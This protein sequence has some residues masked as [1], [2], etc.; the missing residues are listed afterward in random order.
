MKKRTV[1]ILTVG[2][3]VLF[4]CSTAW[5]VSN[6]IIIGSV[7]GIELCPQFICHAAIFTGSFTGRIGSSFNTQGV[8]T[9]A[10]THE[11]LPPPYLCSDITGG[12]W[13]I[14]TLFRRVY[15]TARNGGTICNNG[16]GTFNITA[17]L[18]LG[19]PYNGDIT[20]NGW[21]NHNTL[22]PTFGGTLVQ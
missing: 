20:F 5:A 6:P 19:F 3:I 1:S 18:D 9:A 2:L 13:E 10:L 8:I 4:A 7:L 17:T 22:I 11:D 15:G 16:N 12:V 14:K 21:L